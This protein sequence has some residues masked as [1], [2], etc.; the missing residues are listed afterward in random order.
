M[1]ANTI[2][3]ADFALAHWAQ[4]VID[5]RHTSAENRNKLAIIRDALRE[6][7][8]TEEQ[9]SWVNKTYFDI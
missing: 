6:G 2:M 8:A 3:E 9:R 4:T 5:S 7:F 1:D